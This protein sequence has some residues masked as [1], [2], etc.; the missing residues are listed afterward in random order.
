MVTKNFG[1]FFMPHSVVLNRKPIT[2]Q[3]SVTWHMGSHSVTCH[4][5]QVN[6]PHLNFSQ[7]GLY[8]IY[9][10]RRDRRL[11]CPW[12]WLFMVGCSWSICPQM[13]THPSSNHLI[14]TQPGGKSMTPWSQAQH[15]TATIPSHCNTNNKKTLFITKCRETNKTQ[16]R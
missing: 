2:K 12:C 4:L 3:R 8:S 10:P 7:T 6:V 1:V 11:S 16:Y 15:L 5:T 13:V 9:A 14:A